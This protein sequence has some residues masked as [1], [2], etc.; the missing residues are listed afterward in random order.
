MIIYILKNGPLENIS[1]CNHFPFLPKVQEMGLRL[2][3]FFE[4]TIRQ[5]ASKYLS[6]VPNC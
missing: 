1:L 3:V 5:P 4:E 6:T 2:K